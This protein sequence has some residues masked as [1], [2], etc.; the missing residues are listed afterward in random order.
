MQKNIKP[1]VLL[2]SLLLFTAG[3]YAQSITAGL[4]TVNGEVKTAFAPSVVLIYTIGGIV[5]LIG[6]LICFRKWQSG[7]PHLN[8]HLIGWG[9]SCVFLLLVP[10]LIKTFFGL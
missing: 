6:G 1:F 4:N 3:V 10:T 5:G 2:S 7:D 9:G 8:N